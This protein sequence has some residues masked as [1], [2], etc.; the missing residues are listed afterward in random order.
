MIVV[1]LKGGLGNQLFQYAC[2]R[3][4]AERNH[5]TLALDTSALDTAKTI[6]N[7][8]RPFSLKQ[9]NI[10]AEK[11]SEADIARLA[12]KPTL[13]TRLIKKLRTKLSG[14][15]TVVFNPSVLAKQGDSYLDGYYQSPRYFSEL[16]PILLKEYTLKAALPPAASAYQ[17]KL[18][19]TASVS[20]HV[21][22]GD[23][24]TNPRVKKEFGLCS[25]EY[26]TKAIE[27]IKATVP[28]PTFFIFSDDIPWVQEHLP[29]GY[30]AVYVE[31]ADL[32]DAIELSLMS[33]CQHNII[34]NSSFSWWAAWLNQ[35]PAKHVVTPT[36]WFNTAPYDEHLIPETWTQLAK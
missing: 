34:A 15:E 21:R 24:A 19:A 36:P 8:Y 35:N 32:T 28:D 7:I 9:F 23:Y 13:L 11:A 22:R 1:R 5:D 2:G 12:P 6:G 29:L 10:T 30:T 3:T 16:R 25:I 18:R 26:Y 27:H 33:Q 31:G 14:D 17:A 4:L 20:I